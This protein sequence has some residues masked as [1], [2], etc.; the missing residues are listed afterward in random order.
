MVVNRERV[1]T[2]GHRRLGEAQRAQQADSAVT[3]NTNA[4]LQTARQHDPHATRH[5]PGLKSKGDEYAQARPPRGRGWT[6][7]KLRDPQ[8]AD[9]WTRLIIVAHTQLRL[10]RPL[11]ADH[12][13]PWQKPLAPAQLTP[14][15]IRAGYRRICQKASHPAGPPK[16]SRAGPGRPRGRPNTHKAPVQAVGIAA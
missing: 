7:P 1:S 10:A 9:R 16:A 6:R 3:E 11:A 13:L 14:A 4:F 12:R 5:E 15:R 8:A 2:S